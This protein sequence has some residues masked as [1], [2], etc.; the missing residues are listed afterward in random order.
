ML[1][2]SCI[3]LTKGW[4]ERSIWANV[5]FP[6]KLNLKDTKTLPILD[7]LKSPADFIDFFVA[8]THVELM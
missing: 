1:L 6:H 2:L 3:Y 4:G 5:L 7:F 8:Y